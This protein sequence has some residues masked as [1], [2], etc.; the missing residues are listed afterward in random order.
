LVPS[1]LEHLNGTKILQH[2]I[3]N[4]E[5]EEEEEDKY[6]VVRT[7]VITAVTMKNTDILNVTPCSLIEVHDVSE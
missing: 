2:S 4:N 5:K 7:E 1:Y 6:A 3:P